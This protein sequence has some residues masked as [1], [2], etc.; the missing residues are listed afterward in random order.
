MRDDCT[1]MYHMRH[2]KP[3]DDKSNKM[4]CAP[5]ETSDQPGNP[6]SLISLC[7]P[8]E[9]VLGPKL[10]IERK[11]KTDQTGL[12]AQADLS[13]CWVDRSF[14][15]FCHIPAHSWIRSKFSHILKRETI[16]LTFPSNIPFWTKVKKVFKQFKHHKH[17]GFRKWWIITAKH[18][19][20]A[21]LH[22]GSCRF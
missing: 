7:F 21:A 4:T 13:L 16:W 10:S 15:L 17:L 5:S 2:H 1:Y 19:I 6:P 22:F 14:S 9:E 8:P 18:L 20:S 12:T 11:A 3:E